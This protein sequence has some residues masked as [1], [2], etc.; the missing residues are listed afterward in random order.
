MIQHCPPVQARAA[1]IFVTRKQNL[2][3]T[4]TERQQG[5]AEVP[6]I[7][8]QLLLAKNITNQLSNPVLFSKFKIFQGVH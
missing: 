6:S 2:S 5:E 3:E 8:P 4:L 1:N 7:K